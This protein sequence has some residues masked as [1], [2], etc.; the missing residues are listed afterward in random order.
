MRWIIDGVD[1]LNRVSI[2]VTRVMS[3]I[4]QELVIPLITGQHCMKVIPCILQQTM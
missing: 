1:D 2:L 3:Y 4:Y